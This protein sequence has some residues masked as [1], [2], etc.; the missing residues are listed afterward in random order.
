MLTFTKKPFSIVEELF[1][2][3]SN[4]EKLNPSG[5]L[6]MSIWSH[7]NAAPLSFGNGTLNLINL[8]YWFCRYT[9]LVSK[10]QHKILRCL[11]A[12]I[13]VRWPY[14][15]LIFIVKSWYVER[16][17]HD[18]LIFNGNPDT[19]KDHRYIATGPCSQ[20]CLSFARGIQSFYTTLCI[21]RKIKCD[22]WICFMTLS[23]LR[24]LEVCL[25]TRQNYYFNLYSWVKILL[26]TL[27][28]FC[29]ILLF[30]SAIYSYSSLYC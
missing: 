12:S 13:E 30:H 10:C 14:D 28:P 20:A 5:S 3:W 6:T 1:L 22:E 15:S 8:V 24:L 23:F 25:V 27:I 17:S 26:Y 29:Y 9:Y 16:Q 2:K 11:L 18:C 19:W 4:F 21:G 7:K